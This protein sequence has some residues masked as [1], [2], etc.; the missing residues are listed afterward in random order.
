MPFW[1]TLHSSLQ[2]LLVAARPTFAMTIIRLPRRRCFSC[3]CPCRLI[4][5]GLASFALIRMRFILY[6]ALVFSL[7]V[8]ISSFNVKCKGCWGTDTKV[9]STHE[10]TVS[11]GHQSAINSLT[12]LLA[13][14]MIV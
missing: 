11:F 12:A 14:F 10:E 3:F 13:F 2:F 4:L 9:G 6:L 1:S 7:A 5:V 8:S